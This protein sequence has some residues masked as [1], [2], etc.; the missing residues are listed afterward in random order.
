M[1][2]FFDFGKVLQN[3][4]EMGET[5]GRLLFNS[6]YLQLKRGGV[7]VVGQLQG[8]RCPFFFLL[9]PLGDQQNS[10]QECGQTQLAQ[11]AQNRFLK[12]DRTH[13]IKTQLAQ[14]AFERTGN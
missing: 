1:A 8:Y 13:W 6:L 12:K 9:A 14:A 11:M 4:G 3:M 10:K 7:A 2:I 5:L